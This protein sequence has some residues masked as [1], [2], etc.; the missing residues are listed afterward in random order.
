LALR[1]A[2]IWGFQ[3][4]GDLGA[5]VEEARSAEERLDAA[6]RDR[7]VE[8]LAKDGFEA[9]L[10]NS[11]SDHRLLQLALE[12][13]GMRQPVLGVALGE[14]RLSVFDASGMKELYEKTMRVEFGSN[15]GTYYHR[16]LEPVDWAYDLESKTTYAEFL[17]YAEQEDE[18]GNRIVTPFLMLLRYSE[19]SSNWHPLFLWTPM[20]HPP[21][22]LMF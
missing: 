7:L 12:L 11:A 20:A 16:L 21:M 1:I 18:K 2:S 13:R 17:L 6:T 8:A 22:H 4:S 5:Y 15:F 3:F 14:S 19:R 9:N 10:L